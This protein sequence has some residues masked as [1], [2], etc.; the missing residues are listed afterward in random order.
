MLGAKHFDRILTQLSG[1]SEAAAKLI[2]HKLLELRKGAGN[3][4]WDRQILVFLLPQPTKDVRSTCAEASVSSERYA[5]IER[6]R[7]L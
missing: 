3:L 5:A 4:R 1:E 2:S 7:W 6:A